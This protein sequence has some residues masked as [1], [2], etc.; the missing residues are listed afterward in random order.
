M[1]HRQHSTVPPLPRPASSVMHYG[2]G[3]FCLSFSSTVHL[4][5]LSSKCTSCCR[6]QSFI[7]STLFAV[8]GGLS[9]SLLW[10]VVFVK[11][12]NIVWWYVW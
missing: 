5:S 12:D 7:S 11:Y 1:G 2:S 10:Y 3:Q 6:N 8:I 4:I 9:F